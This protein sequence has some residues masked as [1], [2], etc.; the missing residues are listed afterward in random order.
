[1]KKLKYSEKTVVITGA[2]SGIG[3]KL[4]EC[5]IKKHNC[6]VY[7]IARSQ[8]KLD[9]SKNDLGENYIPYRMDATDKKAWS[10]F[11]EYLERSD[12]RVDI[13]INCAGVLP[14]FK[15]FEKTGIDELESVLK[16]N[17][18]ASA[19]SIKE[20]MPLIN[21]RGA[22]VNVSS[23]SAICPFGG[24]ST[25]TS[26]KSALDNFTVS[27]GCECKDISFSSVLPGFV[28]TD[29]MKNQRLSS[30]EA[31]LIHIFSAKLEKTVRKILRRVARRK[32]RIIVGKDAHFM[33]FIYKFFPR[34]APR[35]IT[36]FLKKSGL[37][38]FNQI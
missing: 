32:R 25:Y 1:M 23:A 30:K 15:S 11:R 13:L 28:R 35:L 26:S 6:R 29:I 10:D 17:F 36:K 2:S 18:L 27:L 9:E 34:L 19:Y 38:L 4:A 33:N 5:L 24:V 8:D 20:L 3:K 31:R 22:V 16:I 12:T 21:E 37:E 14:E 7:A